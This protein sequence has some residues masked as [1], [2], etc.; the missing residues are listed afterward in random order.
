MYIYCVYI[1]I[2]TSWL[3]VVAKVI[4][5][6]AKEEMQ[7]VKLKLEEAMIAALTYIYIE[8]ERLREMYT[9]MHIY[10]ERERAEQKSSVAMG[11]SIAMGI[12]LIAKGRY[13][14]F[15]FVCAMRLY[16]EVAFAQRYDFGCNCWERKH[17]LHTI[18]SFGVSVL[19]VVTNKVETAISKFRIQSTKWKFGGP[20]L[21]YKLSCT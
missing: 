1:Y 17:K 4:V 12:Y 15:Y 18:V 11:G 21:N 10:I 20:N 14:G 16:S 2:Y 19:A 13:E 6:P 5:E 3:K 7:E 8:R 9:Y